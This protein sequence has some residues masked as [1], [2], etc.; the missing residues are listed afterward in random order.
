MCVCVF[1]FQAE[2]GIR[3]R[4]V[5][6]VQTCALPI[7][8]AMED[9]NGVDLQQFRR[10]YGQ[11]GTPELH[12]RG[13]HD[14][15][16]KTYSLTVRQSCPDTAGQKGF[17]AEKSKNDVHEK[18]TAPVEIQNSKQNAHHSSQKQPFHIPIALGLLAADGD[19]LPLKLTGCTA[20]KNQDTII[21]E[22]RKQSEIFVRSEERRVGK[23]CRSRWSPY[24]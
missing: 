6:G 2:G 12:I 24:H 9:A 21:L 5:T 7:F 13:S 4:L 10:W 15:E 17:G 22:L 18:Q 11:S 19:T 20:V 8:A 16:A 14:P 1:F 3:D 23:E